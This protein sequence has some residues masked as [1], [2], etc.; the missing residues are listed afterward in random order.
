MRAPRPAHAVYTGLAVDIPA[1]TRR[2][3]LGSRARAIIYGVFGIALIA[4]AGAMAAS[5][6]GPLQLQSSYNGASACASLTVALAGGHCR[7]TASALVVLEDMTAAVPYVSFTLPEAPG[8]TFEAGYPYDSDHAIVVGSTVP[9]EFWAG[10]ITRVD[11]GATP[12]NPARDPGPADEMIIAVIVGVIGLAGIAWAI[13]SWR[14]PPGESDEPYAAG[15]MNPV[16][17]SQL[18]NNQ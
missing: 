5:V 6:W 14:R 8:R 1:A 11:N 2:Q 12:D 10:R 9:V 4:G 15:A 13:F 3:T 7:Y 16:A 18:F 17:V